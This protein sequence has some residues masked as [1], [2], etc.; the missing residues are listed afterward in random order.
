MRGKKE[1]LYFNVYIST[2]PVANLG[3]SDLSLFFSH[4]AGLGYAV[5]SRENNPYGSCCAEFLLLKT[6]DFFSANPPPPLR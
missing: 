6:E 4:L 1:R 3:F 5:L 2:G